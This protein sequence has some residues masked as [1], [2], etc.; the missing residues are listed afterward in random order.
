[1][2]DFLTIKVNREDIEKYSLK[3]FTDEEWNKIKIEILL[4]N[5][6]FE[7]FNFIDAVIM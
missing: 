1:M 6:G 4:H 5:F 7:I 2:K 3:P